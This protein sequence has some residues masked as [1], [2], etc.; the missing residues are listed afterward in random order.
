MQLSWFVRFN[1][2]AYNYGRHITIHDD[3]VIVNG[4]DIRV[5]MYIA[6]LVG[7]LLLLTLL[8]FFP[9]VIATS[10]SSQRSKLYCIRPKEWDC[11]C[12]RSNQVQNAGGHGGHGGHDHSDGEE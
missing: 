10:A 9:L 12:W 2:I 8:Y 1:G 4:N 7:G 5:I 11:F 3:L 6:Y